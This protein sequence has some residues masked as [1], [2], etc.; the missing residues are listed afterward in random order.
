MKVQLKESSEQ[1]QEVVVFAGKQ[2]KKNNPAV[3]ILK[4]MPLLDAYGLPPEKANFIFL[5]LI[6]SKIKRDFK[7]TLKKILKNLKSSFG[8]RYE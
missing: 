6:I 7:I 8:L 2:S 1:L 5:F 3:E 4:K